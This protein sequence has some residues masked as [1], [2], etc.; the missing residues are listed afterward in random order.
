MLC[1]SAG[2]ALQSPASYTLAFIEV[3]WVALADE[4]ISSEFKSFAAAPH[5]FSTL[6]ECLTFYSK[7]F[8]FRV[9][10]NNCLTTQLYTNICSY[11][12]LNINDLKR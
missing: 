4:R 9:F 12:S 2:E 11:Y 5:I 3:H 10:L 1:C 7:L 6:M 8:P